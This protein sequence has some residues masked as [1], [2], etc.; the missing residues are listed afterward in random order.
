ML[1][2]R[3][4]CAVRSF[5]GQGIAR[6]VHPVMS[7]IDIGSA[8]VLPVN[9]MRHQAVGGIGSKPDRGT[10]I[11]CEKLATRP[12]EWALEPSAGARGDRSNHSSHSAMIVAH[13]SMVR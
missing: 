6:L 9:H 12:R 7:I 1:I 10:S 8:V 11:L 2:I 5:G 13:A 4:I 3:S